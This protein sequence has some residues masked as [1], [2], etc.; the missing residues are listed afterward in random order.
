[1]AHGNRGAQRYFLWM[2]TMMV[3]VGPHALRPVLN[4]KD[5]IPKLPFDQDCLR[6]PYHSNW[7]AETDD[8]AR[9]RPTAHG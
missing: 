5:G 7:T 6:T 2:L 3:S 8:S 9:C 1:M 4:V